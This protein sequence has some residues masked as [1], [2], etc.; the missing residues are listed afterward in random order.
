MFRDEVRSLRRLRNEQARKKQ[1]EDHDLDLALARRPD[2]RFLLAIW[3]APA[4]T[5]LRLV[6][7]DWLEEHGQ[8]GEATF[9]RLEARIEALP[10][11]DPRRSQLAL[12]QDELL[13][14]LVGPPAGDAG[15]P[16]LSWLELWSRVRSTC[17]R[18][19]ELIRPTEGGHGSGPTDYCPRC[20]ASF[21]TEEQGAG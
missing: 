4:D 6:Y 7:A 9:V 5:R 10:T 1:R 11:G 12:D 17:A 8:P 14:A 19:G 20:G 21:V 18:C 16:E 15:L 13:T 2:A 3:A